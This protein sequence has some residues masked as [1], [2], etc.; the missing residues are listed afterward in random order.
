MLRSAG[1][2]CVRTCVL[3]EMRR[4]SMRAI[5]TIVSIRLLLLAIRIVWVWWRLTVIASWLLLLLLRG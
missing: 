3:G 1:Q 2:G 4:W 5:R